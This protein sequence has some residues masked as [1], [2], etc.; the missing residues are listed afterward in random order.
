MKLFAHILL[1]FFS[2][3]IFFAA[4]YNSI[5]KSGTPYLFNSKDNKK[6]E[7]QVNYYRPELHKLYKSQKGYFLIHYDTSGINAVDMSDKDNNGIPDYIDSVAYYF[8]YSYEY[9]VISLMMLSPIPDSGKG[10]S[11]AYDIYVLDIG[12]GKLFETFYGITFNDLLIQPQKQYDRYT[13]FT[14]IDN[15]YSPDDK[16]VIDSNVVIQTYQT[17]GIEALKITAAHELNHAIQFR[18]GINPYDFDL[19]AE[20]TSITIE[21]LTITNSIDYVKYVNDLI[22]NYKKYIFS[23][24]SPENGYRYGIFLIYLT[25]K[26]GNEIIREIWENVQEYQ[27]CYQII[28]EVLLKYNS[29]LN[30]EFCSFIYEL[31]KTSRENL[32]YYFVDSDLFNKLKNSKVEKFANINYIDS[33]TANYQIN[34]ISFIDTLSQNQDSVDFIFVMQDYESLIIKAEKQYKYSLIFKNGFDEG[35]IKLDDIDYYYNLS[36]SNFYCVN[37]FV[38]RNYKLSNDV[39]SFPSP[40]KFYAKEK[41]YFTV[42]YQFKQ[43]L[44]KLIIFNNTF[45]V[46]FEKVL[47]ISYRGNFKVVEL[48]ELPENIGPGIYLFSTGGGEQTYLGKFVVVK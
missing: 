25:K 16:T 11:D 39:I 37:Y 14:V 4:D 46:L 6:I 29:S 5:I 42:P 19:I 47:P 34:F 41:I 7:L 9:Q 13:A 30:I 28:N 35:F 32:S 22:L 10:G 20:M 12:N 45:E 3:N 15:N 2:F 17:N 36:N 27:T 1:F 31:F 43:N 40:Y 33:V 26:Y 48:D 24:P 38:S 18:Y 8:D 44:A 21:K 23:E